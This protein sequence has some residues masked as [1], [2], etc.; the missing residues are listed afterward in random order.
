MSRMEW[1]KCSD[2]MPEEHDSFFS[3]LKKTER[4]FASMWKKESDDV[5][6]VKEFTDGTRMVTHGRTIDGQWESERRQG[7]E[8]KITHWMPF[9]DL[10][11]PEL[12]VE[13]GEQE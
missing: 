9:P 6:I 3:K 2:R 1:I 7:F 8:H 11:F 10:P 13:D 4:W 5:L 12:S